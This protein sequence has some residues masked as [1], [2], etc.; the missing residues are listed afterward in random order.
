MPFAVFD[1]KAAILIKICT[2]LISG[3]MVFNEYI[4]NNVV[5]GNFIATALLIGLLTSLLFICYSHKAKYA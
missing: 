3:L 2:T 1:R 4:I 5:G